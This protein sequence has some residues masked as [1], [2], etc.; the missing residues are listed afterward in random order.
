MG[1]NRWIMIPPAIWI[2]CLMVIQILGGLSAPKSS[3]MPEECPENSRNCARAIMI[4]EGEPQAV[5]NAAMQWIESQSRTTVEAED[6]TTSHTIFSSQWL[7]FPDDMFIET[8]CIG[9]E[10]WIQ[11][12][13]ESRLGWGDYGVN[14]NRID[15]L[16]N[17]LN[18]LEF[19]VSEC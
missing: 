1:K 6:E 4:L 19:E 17:H 13:S 9:N 8:S 3:E 2:A 11:V 18:T 10:T 7:M 15:A 5:H 14:Q 12:H 16:L